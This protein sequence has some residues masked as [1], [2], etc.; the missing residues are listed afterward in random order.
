LL[1]LD[2]EESEETES[3]NEV[4]TI[5]LDANSRFEWRNDRDPWAVV[6]RH[7]GGGAKR[8]TLFTISKGGRYA[9]QWK[10]WERERANYEANRANKR[11]NNARNAGNAPSSSK[12]VVG[13]VP[14]TE[15]YLDN[16]AAGERSS[17]LLH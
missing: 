11:A 7:R 3:V 15:T 2:A 12:F 8:K 9:E 13:K 17:G 4:P 16:T 10:E 14:V 5:R 1:A 6:I